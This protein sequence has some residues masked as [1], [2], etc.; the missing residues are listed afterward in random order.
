MRDTIT[1]IETSV[2]VRGLATFAFPGGSIQT[3]S[4]SRRLEREGQQAHLHVQANRPEHYQSEVSLEHTYDV[5]DIRLLIRGR[6]DGLIVAES[7]STIE[8]I[9]S[10]QLDP[11]DMHPYEV[12]LAQAKLYGAIYTEQH[13]LDGVAI[14]LTYVSMATREE[15]IFDYHYKRSELR[16]FFD[17]IVEHY[18]ENLRSVLRWKLKRNEAIA[19]AGFPFETEREGQK[20]FMEAVT[21]AIENRE[22]LF[23][24]A[25]TGIGKTAAALVPALKSMPAG[26]SDTIFY[27][28]ARTTTQANAEECLVRIRAAGSLLRSVTITAKAKVCF[29][30]L[31]ICE[32]DGCPFAEGYYG[33][34]PEALDQ[35]R[36]DGGGAYTRDAIEI[37]AREFSLCP[38]ELSLDVS[39]HADVVICD[40]NYAFDPMVYLR[41]FFAEGDPSRYILL[42]DEAHNLVDRSMDMFT[43]ILRKRSLL[44]CKKLIDAKAHPALSEAIKAVNSYL[45]GLRK[46]M[47]EEG[48]TFWLAE[49]LDP[50]LEE[51]AAKILEAFPDYFSGLRGDPIPQEI[52]DLYRSVLQFTVVVGL[53]GDGHR[54]FAEMNGS[55]VVVKLLCIDPSEL[56]RGRTDRCRAAVF[57]SATLT[58]FEYFTSL[59]D[60]GEDVATLALDSPFPSENLGVFIDAR[61]S[62][63]YRDRER[64]LDALVDYAELFARRGNCIFFFPSYA[65]L[66]NTLQKLRGTRPDIDV[67][68]QQRGMDDLGRRDFLESFVADHPDG[69]L[70][71]AV[72]GGIFGE[73]IDLVGERLVA[74]V[75]VG[76][77]LPA[78][79]NERDLMKAFYEERFGRGFS[80]AYTYPGM[81]RVLQAAGRVIRS[82]EDRGTVLFFGQRF[83]SNG[84]GKL[85]T[86]EYSHAQKVT[87]SEQV[88]EF[89]PRE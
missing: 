6:M 51:G 56:L 68:V 66:E 25:P 44:S 32:P 71:F 16:Q 61:V 63:R 82:G 39:L 81:N 26:M 47:K 35:V 38:H 64:S 22:K 10:S 4:R 15:R 40:Y 24:R 45:V 3:S 76:V 54:V 5:D 43:G 65:Y 74:A 12:H 87:S 36:L 28:S 59:L 53:K 19:T 73:G 88:G 78:I 72:L 55:D 37:L 70:A 62:T 2:S 34:L 1:P 83:G 69:V 13:E 29:L 20:S 18:L 58:P 27:L 8:E 14:H 49:E 79:S 48:Q 50:D 75:I 46:T 17:D 57:F 85:I 77:G 52:S 23:V 86:P 7:G 84:Y 67:L 30:G 60:D 9:K 80:F 21:S 41:R 42:V 89:I 31:A 11:E 33:R